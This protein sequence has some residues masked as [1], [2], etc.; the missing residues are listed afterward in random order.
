MT[1]ES[2]SSVQLRIQIPEKFARVAHTREKNLTSMTAPKQE[3]QAA[4]QKYNELTQ[5]SQKLIAKISELEMDRNEHRLV[6]DTLRPL[7]GSRRA[8]RLVGEILVERTVEE[9]LP[10]VTGNRE[11]VSRV[12][13]ACPLLLKNVSGLISPLCA[14]ASLVCFSARSNHCGT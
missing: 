7:E 8:F 4:A 14:F 3:V 12:S 11:N 13:T 9:V 10:S 5:E 6:E 2:G 1:K